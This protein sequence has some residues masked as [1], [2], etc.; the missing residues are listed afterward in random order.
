MSLALAAGIDCVVVDNAF[1]R[2]QDF[3]GAAARIRSHAE[4][5]GLLQSF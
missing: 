1:A 4:L 2:G 5:P 3:T